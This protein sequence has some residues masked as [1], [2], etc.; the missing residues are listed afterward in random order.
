MSFIATTISIRFSATQT[1]VI[2]PGLDLLTKSYISRQH[3]G[4]I[5]YEYPFRIYPPSGKFS[6]G[7]FDQNMMDEILALTSQLRPKAKTGGRV[8]INTIELRAAIFAIRVNLD[9]VRKNRNDHR[10][11]SPKAKMR[12]LLDDE[13]YSK[14]K[15]KSEQVILSLERIM[16]RQTVA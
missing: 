9:F 13:S 15:I 5:R 1:A 6:R 16:K 2:W 7:K 11:L 3:K 10:S 8:L 14:L 4:G 12:F